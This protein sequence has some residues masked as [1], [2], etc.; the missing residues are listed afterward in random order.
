MNRVSVITP[1][2]NRWDL[3]RDYLESLAEHTEPGLVEVLV[4]DNGSSDETPR[5]CPGLGR[6]LF[7]DAF[8]Y[9]PQKKNLGFA[10]ASNLGARKASS[11]LLLFLNN[12]ILLSPGW[13]PPLVHRLESTSG[14]VAVGPVLL[15]PG[16]P[17]FGDRVQHLGVVVE[18]RLHVRHLHDLFPADHPVTR[19]RRV[20]QAVTAAAMLVRTRDFL[21]AGMFHEGFVNGGEDVDLCLRLARL[22]P[23]RGVHICEPESR[24]HHLASQTPGRHAHES[25]NAALLKERCLGELLP[26]LHLFAREDGYDCGLDECADIH[27]V[28]PARR[29]ELL[30]RKLA[31]LGEDPTEEALLELMRREPLFAPPY[32]LLGERYRSQGR[33]REELA[34]ARL[35]SSFFPFLENHLHLEKVAG[36]QGDESLS[37]HALA[38]VSAIRNRR[39]DQLAKMALEIAS[40]ASRL[41]MEE[42]ARLYA[43]WPEGHVR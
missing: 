29:R 35:L 9:H 27:L 20:Y 38:R 7:G 2:L 25:Q 22:G 21:D 12:D 24:I 26:D 28:L 13:L 1:V 37:S 5:E 31:S 39:V 32:R 6:S 30:N 10:R 14:A 17:P 43:S 41:G 19:K 8:G 3:T 34:C 16:K 15:Y 36:E 23:E 33:G 4:I 18:P 40:F 11:S 42:V